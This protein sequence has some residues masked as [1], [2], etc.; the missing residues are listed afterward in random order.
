MTIGAMARIGMVCEAMIHGIR[1][2]FERPHVDDGDGKHDAEDA[3]PRTKPSSVE[4]SVTQP[5]IDERA[6]AVDGATVKT[7]FHS[8]TTT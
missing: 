1:L 5:W 7:V 6:S 3:C 8:S 4:E 2:L